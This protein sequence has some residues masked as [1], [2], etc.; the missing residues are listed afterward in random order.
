MKNIWCVLLPALSFGAQGMAERSASTDRPA[1]PSSY[2]GLESDEQRQSYLNELAKARSESPEQ[3]M[4]ITETRRSF[5]DAMRPGLDRLRRSFPVD[6]EETV[7]GGV[8]AYVVTPKAGVAP[9]HQQHVLIN[10]HGGGFSVGAQYLAQ[11]ESIPI[12]AVGGYKV[13]SVDYRLGPENR[14]PAASEDVAKVYRTLLKT[15]RPRDIGLFGCSAG[16]VLTAEAVAWFQSH[17]LPRPGAIG[18]FGAGALI[19]PKGISNQDE[20]GTA[21]SDAKTDMPYFDVAG[22]DT[23]GPLVAP[24]FSPSV[25]KNF[26]ATL[27]ISGTRDPNL[28]PAVFTHAAL[29]QSGV[30]AELHV[31]EGGIHCAFAGHTADNAI[32][33]T[34][35][36]WHVITSFFDRNLGK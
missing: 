16:G 9:E 5:D 24:V 18:M 6:I 35:A 36:A 3:A 19:E 2:S 13:V 23:K 28:S 32:P 29:V 8:R 31:F 10:L 26:P 20:A 21:T 22:L 15:H 4:S 1:T 11:I 17:Q 33:E 25:L 7:I 27:I 30:P 34:R 14:F 12:A